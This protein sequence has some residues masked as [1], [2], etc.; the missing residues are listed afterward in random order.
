MNP[1]LLNY[2]II[3]F[4]KMLKKKKSNFA[5]LN[6]GVN[7]MSCSVSALKGS[8]IT[9]TAWQRPKRTRAAMSAGCPLNFSRFFTALRCVQNDAAHFLK[10]RETAGVAAENTCSME[11]MNAA[12]PAV[13]FSLQPACLSF[14][15][16]ARNLKKILSH[17][18]DDGVVALRIANETAG[19]DSMYYIHTDHLGSYCV[20][21]DAGNPIS[22][23]G[24]SEI[25]INIFHLPAG[26]YFVKITTEKGIITE[27]IVKH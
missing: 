2:F 10:K 5:V 8:G 16:E 12:T 18:G 24:Q 9:N 20:I 11:V 4:K 13:S 25:A 22:E 26:I 23:I 21:T 6:Q 19:T 27:K 1:L 7:M 3:T 14:R 17:Y 15:S